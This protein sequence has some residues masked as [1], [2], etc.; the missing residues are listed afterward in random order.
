MPARAGRS[1]K[2]QLPFSIRRFTQH[3]REK[4]RLGK[5]IGFTGGYPDAK[6]V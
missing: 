5:P 3:G 6:L 4:T 2:I 1:L